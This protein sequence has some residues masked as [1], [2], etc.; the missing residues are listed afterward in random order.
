MARLTKEFYTRQEVADILGVAKKSVERWCWSGELKYI[1]LSTQV[2]RITKK[3][4]Q[5]FLKKKQNQQNVFSK[6]TN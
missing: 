1:K 3:D 5:E 2:V 4:L 6:N